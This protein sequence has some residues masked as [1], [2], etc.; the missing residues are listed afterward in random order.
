MSD[1]TASTDKKMKVTIENGYLV[2]KLPM[3]SPTP[4]SSGKTLVLASTHGNKET[5]CEY[6]GQKIT[7]GVNAYFYKE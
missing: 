5:D 2:I 7:L 6:K 4:S 3:Q 1:K